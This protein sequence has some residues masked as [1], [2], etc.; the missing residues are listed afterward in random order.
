VHRLGDE[1]VNLYP[2]DDGGRV[3][4]VD[5]GYPGFAEA[6]RAARAA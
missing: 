2:V 5:A 3:T 6:A 4:V 1:V